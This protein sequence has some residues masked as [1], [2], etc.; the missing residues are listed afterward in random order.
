MNKTKKIPKNI[1]ATDATVK[2]PLP[3]DLR[4]ATKTALRKIKSD[5]PN[6]TVLGTRLALFVI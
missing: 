1:M 3:A 4:E 5:T 2:Y 6:K